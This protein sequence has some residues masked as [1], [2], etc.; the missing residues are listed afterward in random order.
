MPEKELSERK[1]LIL[2][3]IVESYILGGEPVGSKFLVEN[4]QLECSSATIRNEMAELESMG[5]LEQPHTSA[6]RIPTALGYRF[7]VESLARQYRMT[8]MEVEQINRSLRHKIGE[9]DAILSDASRLVSSFTNYTGIAFRPRAMS[10][11]VTRFETAYLDEHSF[12]LV[13][14]F[15]GGTIKTKNIFTAFSLTAEELAEVVRV[16]NRELTGLTSDG[17]TMQKTVEIEDEVGTLAPLIHPIAKAVY[18]TLCELDGGQ[19]QI[20]GVNHLLEY[21]EY[22]DVSQF[23]EMLDLFEHK[24]NLLRMVSDADPG[25]ELQVHIGSENQLEAMSNSAFIYRTVRRDGKVI[26][27]VGVIGP[28]RMDYSRVIAIL[29]HLSDAI[30][31]DGKLPDGTD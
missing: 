4:Q 11:T 19:M 26:G 24:E 15:P 5:F 14:L 2:K 23:K 20:E 29:N 21:P 13:M 22:S 16:L 9:M 12:V 6:G 28:S 30:E 1:R 10:A 17:I 8:A 3:A 7:Y 27:A 31:S 25:R 18:E